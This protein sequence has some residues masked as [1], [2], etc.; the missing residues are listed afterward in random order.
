MVEYDLDTRPRTTL[1]QLW[2]VCSRRYTA[3]KWALRHRPIKEVVR[4]ARL[5]RKRRTAGTAGLTADLD[6]MRPLV[7]AFV[8]LRPL[9]YTAK[10]RLPARFLDPGQ[11][12]AAIRRL[13]AMG[14]RRQ[15]RPVLCALL[16]AARRL[17]F[18]RHPRLRQGVL[19]HSGRLTNVKEHGLVPLSGTCMA[20]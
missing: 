13:S 6:A 10:E 9:F 1:A 18:Q 11:L 5:R 7:T 15:D 8:H 14:I 12:P 2:R 17:R 20:R 19:A 3:A 16:G 4:G